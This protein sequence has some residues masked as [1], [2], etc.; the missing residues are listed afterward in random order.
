MIVLI[1]L[2]SGLANYSTQTLSTFMLPIL[3]CVCTSIIL[4]ILRT[5]PFLE[6]LF[7][8]SISACPS[9]T[10]NSSYVSS[11]N[12]CSHPMTNR[13]VVDCFY[14]TQAITL[15]LLVYFNNNLQC[16]RASPS[17]PVITI[18]SNDS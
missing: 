4:R 13:I 18:G 14:F 11:L 3:Y 17:T 2:F 5:Y 9:T 10:F 12:C 6:R 8:E 16:L 7:L 15:C 1:C